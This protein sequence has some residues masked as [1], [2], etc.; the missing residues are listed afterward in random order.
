MLRIK[1]LIKFNNQDWAPETI[2]ADTFEELKSR[3]I[4]EIFRTIISL[5]ATAQ[6]K[7]DEIDNDV[8]NGFLD[9]IKNYSIG[10]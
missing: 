3:T 9:E 2:E 4:N 7:F 10:K 6:F 1:L 5:D 8:Y